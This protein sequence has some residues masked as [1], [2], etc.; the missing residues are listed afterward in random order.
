MKS[1]FAICLSF[2]LASPFS[3]HTIQNASVS[4]NVTVA[5]G[6][7]SIVHYISRKVLL[8]SASVFL[9]F[10]LATSFDSRCKKVKRRTGRPAKAIS[11]TG[12]V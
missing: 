4:G 5:V 12:Y 6:D 7:D 3:A 8:S 1:L 10:N 11:G 2:L 9:R